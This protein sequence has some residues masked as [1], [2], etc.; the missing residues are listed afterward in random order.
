MTATHL[1]QGEKILP[2]GGWTAP[3][4]THVEHCSAN[5]ETGDHDRLDGLHHHHHADYQF[6]P[7]I[8]DFCD[9]SKLHSGKRSGSPTY[10]AVIKD[11]TPS[12]ADQPPKI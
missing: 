7:M 5:N 1:A 8:S 11:V 2:D 4:N 10:T 6:G 3:C 9:I 12:S